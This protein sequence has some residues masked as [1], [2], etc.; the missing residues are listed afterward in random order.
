MQPRAALKRLHSLL[1]RHRPSSHTQLPRSRCRL[2]HAT[3]TYAT[4]GVFKALTE[5]R[6]RT[7]WIEALRRS[8]EIGNQSAAA[9]EDPPKP[10]L[11]PKKMSDSYVSVVLPLLDDP[12]ML[13]TYANYSGQLRTGALLMDLDALA[14]VV[15]YKHT[16]EGVSTVTAA[17]D[18]ITIK[19]PL[20]EIC[21]LELSGQ[22]TFATGR[23]SME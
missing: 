18:R 1:L 21:N 11:T 5:M 16:G 10:D 17:V 4:D 13:D 14:G 20:R 22:V 8:K 9:P 23:S 19:N 7:P 6:V 2:F 15:A 12:W 3:P